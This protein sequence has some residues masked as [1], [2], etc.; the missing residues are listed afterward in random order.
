MTLNIFTDGASR[1]NPGLAGI[2]VVIHKDKEVLEKISEF[3]GKRTNNEAEYLAC[4]R[5]LERAKNIGDEKVNI[6]CDSEFLVKQLKGEYA[7]KSAQLKPL[8]EVASELL[9]ELNA[10]IMWVPREE[11]SV[12]DSLANQGIDERKDDN[13][14]SGMIVDKAF[15]GK[16]NCLKIQM[17]SQNAVYFHLGLLDQKKSEWNWEKVKMSDMEL[18]DIVSLLKKDKGSTS[19]FHSYN[20]KKT[21]IWCN[22]DPEKFSIKINDVSKNLSVGELEVLRVILEK[23]IE[24][25]NF[26]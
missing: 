23:C 17:S 8:Y 25:M 22:K 19:F 11:N 15:F 6:F 13:G 18:G 2:G 1:G 26:Y 14:G 20:D 24:L 7:I 10:K 3:V 12:A 21:Q 4:I 16:I 9:K 5:G